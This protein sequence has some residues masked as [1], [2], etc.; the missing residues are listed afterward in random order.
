MG[1]GALD[2]ADAWAKIERAK[3]LHAELDAAI[4]A[5]VSSGGVEAQSRRSHQFVC[6]KGFAKVN[7]LPPIN[8]ALRAGEVLHALRT[9]LDYTAFQ[10]YV[11]G[12]GSPNGDDAH[13]VE[14][15]IVDDP[16]KLDGIVRRK[17]PG[18]WPEAVDELR[19]VQQSKQPP[20]PS[21]LPPI[22]P[23]LTRLRILGGTDKHR[24]LSL[25]ATGAWSASMVAPA[26]KPWYSISV[27]MYI[28]GPLLPLEVGKKV[29]VSRVAAHPTGPN[30]HI[31]D[32]FLWE[33]GIEL[34]K[35][36]PPELKFGFR[37]NDATEIDTR[38]LPEVIG[39]VESVVQRFAALSGP[40]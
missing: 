12:G 5:W 22:A 9:A 37:A 11:V 27:L 26:M 1:T 23:L 38:E 13:R 32:T 2:L 8:L 6:Y 19:A 17:V 20:P 40:C 35:P 29:E 14:F 39:L 33:S 30:H 28:P 3:E 7:A 16:D 34:E 24:N 18:A 31:D 25:V 36:A 21:G 10:I 15:P 4:S